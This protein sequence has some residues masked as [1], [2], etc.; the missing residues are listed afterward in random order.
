M[1]D[2]I[3][4]LNEHRPHIGGEARCLTCKHEWVAVAPAGTSQLECPEC[5][6]EMGVFK[7][8]VRPKGEVWE[9]GCGSD[10]FHILPAGC[11]CYKC[12]VIQEGF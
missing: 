6:A 10:L 1:S 3:V 12:G 8:P 5:E 9:C 4:S 7:Y 2:N 11:Q